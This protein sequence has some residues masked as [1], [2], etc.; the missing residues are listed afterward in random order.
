MIFTLGDQPLHVLWYFDICKYNFYSFHTGLWVN[1]IYT[2]L[3][4]TLNFVSFYFPPLFP[5]IAFSGLT[6]LY[7]HGCVLICSIDLN[8]S[9]SLVPTYCFFRCSPMGPPLSSAFLTVNYVNTVFSHSKILCCW[10][11][12]NCLRRDYECLITWSDCLGLYYNVSKWKSRTFSKVRTPISFF[13]FINGVVFTSVVANIRDLRFFLFLLLIPKVKLIILYVKHKIL[14]FI[15][16]I[17]DELKLAISLKS[18]YCIL[19]CPIIDYGSVVW[20]PYTAVD[21]H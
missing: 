5:Y 13:Y 11:H 4:K 17:T 10:W 1:V 18:L 14:G 12:Y 9:N 16:W 20:N 7:Y 2:N 19:V 8:G 15:K 21:C 6:I 3:L